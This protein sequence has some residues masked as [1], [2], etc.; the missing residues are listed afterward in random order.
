MENICLYLG[1]ALVLVRAT[2][3][4]FGENVKYSMLLAWIAVPT[5][6]LLFLNPAYGLSAFHL[7]MFFPANFLMVA[8]VFDYAMSRRKGINVLGRSLPSWPRI[9]R[10]SAV[11]VICSLTFLISLSHT[12]GESPEGLSS[13]SPVG[14]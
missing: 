1:L 8:L 7:T 9:A 11:V 10:I 5:L 13:S 4:P 12:A 6:I 3:Q 2:R 14:A